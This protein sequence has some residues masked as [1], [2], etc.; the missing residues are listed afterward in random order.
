M[1][2][3]SY[4]TNDVRGKYLFKF[5]SKRNLT[6]FLKSGAIWFSR[7]D[8]FG[9]KMECVRIN[10]LQNAH[11]D[12]NEID[13]RKKRHLI[14][15]WHL[16]NN[17]SL[18][19]WDTYSATPEDRRTVA[20][21][22]RRLDLIEAFKDELPRNQLPVTVAKLIH[23]KVKYK[24]LLTARRELLQEKKVKYPAFRKE[25]VFSYE[26]EYRFVIR[27]SQKYEKLGLGYQIGNLKTIPFDI[28]VNPLLEK[29]DYIAV[30]KEVTAGRFGDRFKESALTRWLKPDQW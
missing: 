8:R 18:A 13:C 6:R 15:C 21:R 10:D 28:L 30:R 20:I 24:N 3:E 22:F 2:W 5:L 4:N 19:F 16:A 23:G 25:Y 29:A 14:S 26:R 7:S 1:S 27:L 12:L 11:L 9:D 17:E